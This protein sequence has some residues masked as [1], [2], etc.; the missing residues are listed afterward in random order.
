MTPNQQTTFLV[1]SALILAVSAT[2]LAIVRK[3]ISFKDVKEF[4]CDNAPSIGTCNRPTTKPHVR[5]TPS[6]T[7]YQ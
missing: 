7:S 6:G 5:I 4:L 1:A 3:N 2:S